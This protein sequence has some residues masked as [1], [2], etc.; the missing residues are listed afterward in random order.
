MEHQIALKI[1]LT[2]VGLLTTAALTYTGRAIYKAVHS[3]SLLETKLDSIVQKTEAIERQNVIQ[4][5]TLCKVV[6]MQQ[7]NIRAIRSM[8]Y[9]MKESGFNGSIK[10]AFE[11]VDEW[12]NKLNEAINANTKIAL[13]GK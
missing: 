1:I 8:C 3:A 9:S 6:E 12:E 13:G 4:S 11:H 2:A 10:H 5:N 7:P